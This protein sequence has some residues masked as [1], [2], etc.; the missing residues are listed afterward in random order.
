MERYIRG[1]GGLKMEI[2][3]VDNDRKRYIDLL[4]LADEEEQMIDKY[5]SR[6]DMYVAIDEG[7]AIAVIVV[8][9]EG[10]GTLEIKNLAVA[11]DRQGQ[12]I[13]R[14]M[15][16]FIV[17]KYKD[18]FNTLLVGTGDSPVTT[19]F[20]ERCGFARSHVIPDFFRKNYS[21]P[22]IDGGVL[23]RDMVYFKMEI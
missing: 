20:Y 3:R 16:G 2:V 1:R 19:G 10:K 18:R 23:L 17:D 4:I 22:I 8:T 9:D 5:L 21:H 11:P 14:E 12:G 7:K 13:G 6:G 15:V